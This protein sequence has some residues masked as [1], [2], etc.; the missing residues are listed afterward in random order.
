L[1]FFPHPPLRCASDK[2][3][4]PP[5]NLSRVRHTTPRRRR[6]RR[7]HHRRRATKKF[8]ANEKFL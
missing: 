1:F 7:H 8:C 6:R 3:F 2:I 4:R 5:T